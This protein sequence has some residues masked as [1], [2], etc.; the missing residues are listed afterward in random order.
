MK[1]VVSVSLGSSKRDHQVEASFLGENFRIERRGTDGDFQKARKILAELD[2][3]VDAIG[4]GG[5]DV[6]IYSRK[7]RY[8]LQDG[9]E[10]MHQV[11]QTP[12]ADGSGLKNT[13]ERS[14]IEYLSTQ[15]FIDFKGLK[16]LMVCAMDR[17]GMAE[18]LETAGSKMLYGDL[19]FTLEIEKPLHT[20]EELD[21]YA[22]RLLPEISALPIEL[23]YPTGAKQDK[24][25]KPKF[26]K[27]YLTADAIAGDFHYIKRFM[28]ARLDGKII[29]T[30]TVTQNDVNELRERKVRYLITTT[31]EL[32][33]RSFGTNVLQ[34]V[35]L[36]LLKK[37]EEDVTPE[38]YLQL[39]KQ[40]ELKP[41]IEKLN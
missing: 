10:L 2:G 13:L 14:V 32:S 19:I 16:V 11:K 9:L 41:R 4:L 23:I 6:Y 29:I 17:F 37:K 31:P 25:S 12:V 35:F 27:Y 22:E 8:A 20:L 28:P 24:I 38:E 34:A 40:L 39:I 3:N 18:A 21:S 33:G 26:D 7:K 36:A 15:P 5:I 30:N 1:T